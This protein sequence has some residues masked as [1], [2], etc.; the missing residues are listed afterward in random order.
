M[1]GPSYAS[2]FRPN[3]TSPPHGTTYV[4]ALNL[5]STLSIVWECLAVIILCTW[6]VQHLNVPAIRPRPKTFLEMLKNALHDNLTKVKWMIL[7]ILLPEYL[8]GKAL[9]ERNAARSSLEWTQPSRSPQT[10][11]PHGVPD[12]K[13]DKIHAYMA[14]AGY[15]VLD[16]GRSEE[17]KPGLQTIT[18]SNDS[19][20][21][22][23]RALLR[24]RYWALN[25]KQ[26]Y[27]AAGENGYADL[28]NVAPEHLEKLNRSGVFVKTLALLQAAY[29]IIQLIV[30]KANNLP[31]SQLEIATL[32]F[33]ASSAVA[34][35]LYWERPQGVE[36]IFVVQP[37]AGDDA[38]AEEWAV[39]A[40]LLARYGPAY[41]WLG[42]RTP[43]SFDPSL[44][45][46]PI[47][48]DGAGKSYFVSSW[49]MV[50]HKALRGLSMSLGSNDELAMLALGAVVGG[51]LFGGLHC[52]AWNSSFHTR[53]EMIAWRVCS[54]LTTMLPVGVVMP[55]MIW[56]DLNPWDPWREMSGMVED[57]K[58]R[59]RKVAG[60]ILVGFVVPYVLA[61]LFLMV[62][63]FLSLAYLPPEAFTS[64][65]S[66][67][68][69]H[70]G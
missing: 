18:L 58:W 29:H 25:S 38:T 50:R 70:W 16:T 12:H 19:S 55:L 37:K 60:I 68:L 63:M 47:P 40:D 17:G 59:K 15:F 39:R 8:I 61:R 66:A 45:P 20:V 56:M 1:T 65:W 46:V 41:L 2:T 27:I 22:I 43:I 24:H 67:S 21:A 32:A 14:N 31:S 9:S 10:G 13:W 5:R 4:S 30:R 44:G 62:E 52:L 35:I 3:C 28:P 26:W 11:Q 36:T 49:V 34:F 23:N 53:G 6:S 64:T 7:T 57:A 54:I 51:V 42:Y 69:P 33:A 48:N